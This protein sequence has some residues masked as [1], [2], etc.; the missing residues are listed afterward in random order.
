MG[1]AEFV[2]SAQAYAQDIFT[3]SAISEFGLHTLCLAVEVS[4]NSKIVLA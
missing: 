2:L 3:V 4:G 1:V